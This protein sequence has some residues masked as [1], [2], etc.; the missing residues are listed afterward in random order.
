M[1][2]RQ[3]GSNSAFILIPAFFVL[4]LFCLSSL[5]AAQ[6]TAA[7][8]T[9]PGSNMIQFKAGNHILGFAPDKAYLA[10]MDHALSVHFLGTEGVMPKTDMT[11][12]AAIAGSTAKAPSLSK[13]VYQDLWEGISLTYVA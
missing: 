7:S 12:A 10:S 5:S 13:V 4:S 6:E 11:T 2:N 8:I 3:E 1:K 9:K